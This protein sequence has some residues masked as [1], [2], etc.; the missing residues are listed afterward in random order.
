MHKSSVKISNCIILTCILFS[1]L[2]NAQIIPKIIG[3]ITSDSDAW[4]WMAGLLDKQS[5]QLFCGASLIA[6]KWVLTAAH[7][8]INEKITNLDVIINRNQLDSNQ[9]ERIS[10][11]QIILHPLYNNQTFDNDLAL[12]KLSTPSTSTPIKLLSAYTFQDNAKKSA[13]ALGWGTLSTTSEI[14]PTQLQQV[15]L[16][17]ID[18]SSCSMAMEDITE[19]M[20]CAGDLNVKKDTC[21]GDSGGPLIVFDEES[22]AWKQAGITSWGLGCAE[23]DSYG[24]YT[25]IKNYA[26]FISDH[27]CT[28]DETPDPTSLS[29]TINKNNASAFWG[30]SNKSLKNRNKVT[31]QK[32]DSIKQPHT[33]PALARTPLQSRSTSVTSSTN[34]TGFRLNYASFPEAQVIYSLDMNHLTEFSVKL[35]SGSAFYVAITS[36]IGNCIS[37]FSNIEHFTID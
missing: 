2:S 28:K 37:E 33:M 5:D 14:F 34:I 21:L 10:V 11:N 7:C 4:P 1:N 35:E 6:K 18:N 23:P 22:N 30:A 17:I 29:L 9:G 16:P 15:D 32:A 13:I 8:V 27:I 12:L 26:S 25:R 20:L 24:V 31:T 36:Y 19:N 3:G